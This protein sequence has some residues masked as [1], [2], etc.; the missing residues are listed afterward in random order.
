VI[1]FEVHDDELVASLERQIEEAG[2]RNGA[3]VSLIGGVEDFTI[4]TMPAYD[5]TSDMITDYDVVAEMTGTGEIVD[6]K[7]HIH[8]V[9]GIEGDQARAGHLHRAMVKTHFARAYVLP[10]TE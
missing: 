8:V 4:S 7:P 10:V 6:G 9:M 3:I 1:V 5:A 2:I